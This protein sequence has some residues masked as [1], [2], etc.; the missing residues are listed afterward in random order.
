MPSESVKICKSCHVV[1]VSGFCA[2]EPVQR[3]EPPTGP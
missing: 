1:V 2:P 3:V